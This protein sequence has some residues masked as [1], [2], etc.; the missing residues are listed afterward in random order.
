M[1]TARRAALLGGG[2]SAYV[3]LNFAAG[4]FKVG[5]SSAGDLTALSGWSFTRA[6]LAM[7]YDSTG[8][9]VY[10]PNNLALQS[11]TL[12]NASWAKISAVVTADAGT[13]PDGTTTADKIV[14]NNGVVAGRVQQVL[15][16]MAGTRYLVSAYVKPS[17]WNWFALRVAE[18]AAPAVYFDVGTGALGAVE[19]GWSS[20]S[21]TS[22]GNG[23][24]RIAAV[25]T[26]VGASYTWRFLPTNAN[27]AFTTGDGVNG[28]LA[29]GIQVEAVTYQTTPGTYNATTSAAYYGPRLVYDPVTLASLGILVEEARTNLCLQSQTFDNASWAKTNATVSVNVLVSPDGTANADK[30]VESVGTGQHRVDQA[31]TVSNA[32]AYTFSVFAKADTRLAIALR[33]IAGTTNASA[34][35]NL[36]AGTINITSAGTSSITAVGGG[37]YLCQVT[38]TTTSTSATA[39]I[40]LQDTAGGTSLGSYTGDGTSGLYLWQAQLEAG[41]GASSP[42]PT[43]TAAVTRAA[44]DATLTVSIASGAMVSEAYGSPKAGQTQVASHVSLSNADDSTAWVIFGQT[45]MSGQMT[46]FRRAA[47]VSVNTTTGSAFAAGARTKMAMRFGSPSGDAVS[48]NGATPIAIAAAAAPLVVTQLRIGRWAS[49]PG[50]LNNTVARVRLYLPLLTDAQ[51]QSLTS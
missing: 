7:G 29:W 24:Y 34:I 8:K 2:V 1:P 33:I 26:A 28:S 40:N 27:S 47:G 43:T 38:G 31:I 44:D 41:T 30:L 45:N 11:Q 5:A 19:S 42:I 17:G 6:S 15:S 9:L 51:L 3:D 4:M 13:A 49:D 25:Y 21:I 18:D 36:Q 48:V 20:A 14:V 16:A 35:F 37:W 50:Y 39:Y 32:T 23:W 12:D 10:G 46:A 22:A